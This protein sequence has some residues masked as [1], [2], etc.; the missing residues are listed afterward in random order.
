MRARSLLLSSLLLAGCQQAAGPLPATSGDAASSGD[1]AGST[2]GR[3]PHPRPPAAVIL[4]IRD[5]SG[6]AGPFRIAVLDRLV[7]GVKAVSVSPGSHS[8]RLDVLGPEG[9]LYATF[10][11]DVEADATYAGTASQDLQVQGTPIESLHRTG[12]WV[13]QAT[14]DGAD[15]PLARAEAQVTE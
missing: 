9:T 4:D 8:I 13:F 7:V 11:V 3:K 14:L 15:R 5:G 6:V 2:P 10:P 12:T 1:A